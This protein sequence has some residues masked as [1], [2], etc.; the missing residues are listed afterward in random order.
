MR[1]M[2]GEESYYGFKGGKG[3]SRKGKGKGRTRENSLLEKDTKSKNKKDGASPKE[4]EIALAKPPKK[5]K[6]MLQAFSQLQKVHS[7]M[8][9]MVRLGMDLHMEIRQKCRPVVS[10]KRNTM[11]PQ[12]VIRGTPRTAMG[13][14]RMPQKREAS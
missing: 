7:Q 12:L 11:M 8:P 5:E 14:T 1:N 4:K 13:G 9:P 3:K 10:D 2:T 6:P